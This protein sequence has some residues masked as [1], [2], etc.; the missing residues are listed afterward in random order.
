M[1]SFPPFCRNSEQSASMPT[2]KCQGKTKAMVYVL[3]LSRRS[4]SLTM[5][6]VLPGVS[7]LNFLGLI[8]PIYSNRLESISHE[9][10]ASKR[11]NCCASILPQTYNLADPF[12]LPLGLNKVGQWTRH[13][14]F[15]KSDGDQTQEGLL[16]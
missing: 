14:L 7:F 8:S 6:M 16:L 11:L 3:D 4:C 5:K 13:G 2:L 12:S 9:D 10:L 15:V 1:S